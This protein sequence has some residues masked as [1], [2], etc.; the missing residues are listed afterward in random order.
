M[1]WKLSDHGHDPRQI[2]LL[3]V[4]ALILI[5]I[6]AYFYYADY[7]APRPHTTSFIVPSQNVRW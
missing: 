7:S 2:D 5:S 6:G 4:V 3:A 1:R